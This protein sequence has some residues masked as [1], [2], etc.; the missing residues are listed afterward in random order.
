MP[1]RRKT[2]RP[3]SG[4]RRT[5]PLPPLWLNLLL[6][7][8]GLAGMLIMEIG[9][10]QQQQVLAA[11]EEATWVV[12]EMIPDLAGIDRVVVLSRRASE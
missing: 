1:E 7:A 8:L 4:D 10:G 5:F 9:Y 2:Q 12:D 3:E 11:A 6:L